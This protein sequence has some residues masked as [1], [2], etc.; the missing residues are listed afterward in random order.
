VWHAL[1]PGCSPFK[2]CRLYSSHISISHGAL[3]LVIL[4]ALL[5]GTM[6]SFIFGESSP[7][8]AFQSPQTIYLSYCGNP[9][10][11]SCIEHLASSS[12]IPLLS[13]LGVGGM[14]MLPIHSFSPPYTSMHIP[15]AYSFPTYLFTF[16]PFLII[17]A[18]PPLLPLFLLCSNT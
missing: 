7:T 4:S 8:R 18:I 13:K 10:M 15:C 2:I 3:L 12:S 6:V 5:R 9:S 16:I 17:I 14:Y 11:I 1:G